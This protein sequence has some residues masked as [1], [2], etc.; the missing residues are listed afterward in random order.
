MNTTA[1]TPNQY[2]ASL[3]PDRQ[4]VIRKLRAVIREN[5]PRGFEETIA[6]GMLAWVVPHSLYPAGYHCDP[7]KPLPFMNLASQKQYV[8][9][10]HMALGV[11]P[12]LSWLRTE[13][14]RHTDEKL[15]AGKGCLRFRKLDRIPCQLV[16]ELAAKMT[17]Q[18][19]IDAYEVALEGRAPREKVRP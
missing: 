8:S 12:L 7:K 19:W 9:L 13:W 3:P 5:L 10:Y 14:P 1:T 6:Y 18:E 15:D 11:G 4:K 17:P 16:G 2:I